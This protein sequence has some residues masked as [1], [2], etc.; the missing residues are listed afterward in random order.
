MASRTQ[1]RLGQL[2][3]SLG[4]GAGAIRPDADA[5]ELSSYT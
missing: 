3:G 1:A 5:G 4:T 2:T